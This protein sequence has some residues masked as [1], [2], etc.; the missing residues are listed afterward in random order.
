MPRIDLSLEFPHLR[1]DTLKIIEAIRNSEP[2]RRVQS[3]RGNVPGFYP[4]TKMGVT[5]QFESHTVEFPAIYQKEYDH[6]VFEY[7]DQ[8][9]SF[10]ISYEVNGRKKG[11]LYTADFFVIEK[12]WIGWEEW[13]KESDL[14]A[15]LAKQSNRYVY[16]DKGKWR[17]PAAESYAEQYGLSFRVKTEK[18]INYVFQRNLEFLEDYILLEHPRIDIRN[19]NELIRVVKQQ[20]GITLKSLLDSYS[21]IP[22][23]D[24]Y[25]SILL[26]HI[27][28]DLEKVALADYDSVLVFPDKLTEQAYSLIVNETKLVRER[29]RGIDIHVGAF[30]EWDGRRWQIINLGETTITLMCEEDLADLPIAMFNRLLTEGKISGLNIKD[31]TADVEKQLEILRT[32]SEK[33]LKEANYRYEF[34]V[35]KL[36]GEKDSTVPERTLRFW[37]S[38]YQEAELMYGNGYV[39]LIPKRP[40]QGNFTSK[41]PD[42]VIKLTEQ[43]IKDNYENI[44]QMN[45]ASVYKLLCE[46]C[47]EQGLI[48][49]SYKTFSKMIKSRS[50]FNVTRKRMGSKAAYDVEPLFYELSTTTPRHGDRAFE[51]CHMDHTELDVEIVC[52][53][54]GKNLGRPWITYLVD[55]YSRRILSYY[56]TFDPPSYRSCMMTLREC[57]RRHNRLPKKLI[58][59][60]GKEFSSTYFDTLLA[61]YRVIKMKRP[62]AKPRFG[63]VCERLFGTTNKMFIHNLMGNTQITKEVRKITKEVNPRLN[64]VW[65]LASLNE[66]LREFVYEIY[67]TI[68][69]PALG[70]SPREAFMQSIARSGQRSFTMIPYDE[71][72]ILLTMPSTKKGTAK[73]EPSRGIKINNRY[74]WSE[75]LLNP[76]V[77]GTQ[78]PVRYDPFNMGI[79]YAFV[80]NQWVA[81]NSE[82]FTSF[83]NRT[84]KEIQIATAELKRRSTK[85]SQ[86]SSISSSKLAQFLK[87]VESEEVLQKQRLKDLEIKKIHGTLPN[88]NKYPTQKAAK[89]PNLSVVD[90]NKPKKSPVV[91]QF[92]ELEEL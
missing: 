1:E 91:N 90:S 44:K 56:L 63:S 92:V 24:I 61:S 18:E 68:E 5:I 88:S 29:T 30:L 34:V 59:D 73:V 9:P 4:S 52:S 41:L 38:Q 45:M 55:A 12:S 72:F 87:D 74:Y 15:L 54:T 62:G 53:N 40:K 83:A 26:G 3:G 65:T 36:N 75:I 58:V 25:K 6:D 67:D 77:E 32:A 85:H 2:A 27:Y 80:L 49:P 33:Q 66:K 76:Q 17:C 71:T 11:H 48:S 69:H 35:K 23:D 8:P 50:K 84:E 22:A 51:V 89:Q 47:R 79:A 43:F 57:V 42:Q 37:M 13:K 16:D 86:N 21:H 78:V 7:Y 60:G 31:E 28:T 46:A 39:G 20:P 19:V 10:P 82:N 64:A 70:Q 14:I 81:L